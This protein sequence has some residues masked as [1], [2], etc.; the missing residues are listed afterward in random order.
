MQDNYS[1][2]AWHYESLD[3][4]YAH[5]E[6]RSTSLETRLND[7]KAIVQHQGELLQQLSSKKQGKAD[8][9]VGEPA[10]VFTDPWS[11]EAIP[12]RGIP[13]YGKPSSWDHNRPGS[14]DSRYASPGPRSFDIN[15]FG[16]FSSLNPSSTTP[17]IRPY[18]Q[19][20]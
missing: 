20:N 10:Q 19:C 2:L 9:A 12:L 15:P 4:R 13:G 3:S 1:L 7:L 5:M 16:S 6:A 11:G 8:K 18:I 14:P 17:T